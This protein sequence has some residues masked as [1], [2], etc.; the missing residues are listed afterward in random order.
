MLLAIKKLMGAGKYVVKQIEDRIKKDPEIKEFMKRTGQYVEG[1]YEIPEVRE[2]RPGHLVRCGFTSPID[3]NFGMEVGASAV[4]LALNNIFGVTV[5]SYVDGKIHYMDIKEA[6]QQ[7]FVSEESIRIYEQMGISFGR[8]PQE[9]ID[10]KF[11]KVSGKP[12]R[13]Y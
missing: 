4:Y 11:E 5:V 9:K 6:I 7:R 12:I 3:A 2:I 1:V 8:K 13:P 10:L